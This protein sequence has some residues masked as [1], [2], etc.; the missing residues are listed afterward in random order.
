MELGTFHTSLTYRCCECVG[1]GKCLEGTTRLMISAACAFPPSL[2]SVQLV[3]LILFHI[4]AIKSSLLIWWI[5]SLLLDLLFTRSTCSYLHA[6]WFYQSIGIYGVF[7][8]VFYVFTTFISGTP[9]PRLLSLHLYWL[10][11][12]CWMYRFSG[13]YCQ[14]IGSF[15][16][17]SRWYV[18]LYICSNTSITHSE[19]Q[20]R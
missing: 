16:L 15:S 1:I 13:Q 11:Y 14:A 2:K 18:K 6:C 12:Q 8:L 19:L 7:W 10:S 5:M 9:S 20:N 3:D 4:S 17:C